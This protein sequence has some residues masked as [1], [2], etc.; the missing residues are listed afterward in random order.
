MSHARRAGALVGAAALLGLTASPA[1][2][3]DAG[4]ADLSVTLSGPS[5]GTAG[6]TGEFAIRVA[7][8]GST[9]ALHARVSMSLPADVRVTSVGVTD[10]W[11]CV[12]SPGDLSCELEQ[13]LEAGSAAQ[14][15]PVVL[16][17]DAT[18][19]GTRELAALAEQQAGG[20]RVDRGTATVTLTAAQQS[21]SPTPAMPTAAPTTAA[22]TPAPAPATSTPR[23]TQTTAAAAPASPPPPPPVVEDDT[24]AAPSVE[25][26]AEPLPVEEQVPS[27]LPFVAEDEPVAEPTEDPA[28]DGE[29]A[30]APVVDDGISPSVFALGVV[31]AL[32]VLAEAVLLGRMLQRRLSRTA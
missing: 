4:P 18:A 11:A 1:L 24:D 15:I 2:A 23:A 31:V 6:G 14:A 13:V 12:F 22:P 10:D 27:S 28:D 21:A 32:L 5:T 19:S 26:F 3:Q 17:Y 16:G 29:L 30:A 7:N 8:T 20:F 9:D 25:A